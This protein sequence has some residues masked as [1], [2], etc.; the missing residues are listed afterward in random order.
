MTFRCAQCELLLDD[1]VDYR[2][3]PRCSGPIHWV[4]DAPTRRAD[5]FPTVGR[6]MTGSLWLVIGAQLVFAL[7]WPHDF[8]YLRPL[9]L[10]IQVGALVGAVMMLA[11][12][13]MMRAL[14]DLRTRIRHGLEH[15]TIAVLEERGARVAR[16]MTYT[17]SFDIV[18][19]GDR[20]LTVDDIRS[21]A[22]AAIRRV[23]SGE[24]ALVYS[25][26]CGTSRIV[27][28][29]VLAMAI[30]VVGL[31]AEYYRVPA[32]YTFA[33]TALACEL[34]RRAAVPLGLWAQ[35]AW[36]VEAHFASATVREV[37][38]EVAA[39]GRFVQFE[40]VVD[41]EPVK[42]VIGEPV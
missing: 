37:A 33:A 2:E 22:T 32:G 9:L 23:A 14:L 42:S 29:G 12:V 20:H 13:P 25:P 31:V 5:G 10:V 7:I 3:C 28:V 8:P 21:A 19:E 11:A 27:G 18:M 6:M 15:A 1:G 40:V 30:A 39:T 41:V 26:Q 35:R 36:T 16:G 17:R 38:R 24:R 34:A 4:E